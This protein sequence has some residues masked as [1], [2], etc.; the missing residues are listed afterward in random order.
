MSMTATTTTSTPEQ[1][2]KRI[3]RT[4]AGV[5]IA[6]GILVVVAL[7][8]VFVRGPVVLLDSSS[9]QG[10]VQRYASAAVAGD[11][12]EASTFLSPD[13]LASCDPQEAYNYG[14]SMDT[15]VRVTLVGVTER[16]N[17][18][19]V[20]VLITTTYGDGSLGSTPSSSEGV[21]ELIKEDQRWLIDTAPWELTICP[22]SGASQ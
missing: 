2:K 8:V 21:F 12:A 14:S 18:A 22:A 17:S 3:D 13:W 15:S 9:P 10:V 20:Q 5:I 16:P 6:I 11:E 1:P 7:V 4:L 19:D